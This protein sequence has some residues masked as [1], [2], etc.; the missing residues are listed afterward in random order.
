MTPDR[1][2]SDS[3]FLVN[4][5]LEGLRALWPV[6]FLLLLGLELGIVV[7]A[8]LTGLAWI[9]LASP[10]VLVIATILLMPSGFWGGQRKRAAQRDDAP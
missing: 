6:R 7:V 9:A 3:E 2:A 8:V 5:G 1:R 4:E 10:L